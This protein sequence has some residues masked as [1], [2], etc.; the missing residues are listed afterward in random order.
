MKVLLMVII[1]NKNQIGFLM[2]VM[3]LEHMISIKLMKGILWMTI[4][5]YPPVPAK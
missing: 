4:G 3:Y 1:I 2:L 5:S